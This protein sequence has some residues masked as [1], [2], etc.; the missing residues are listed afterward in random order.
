MND[1][2]IKEEILQEKAEFESKQDGMDKRAG[3]AE[4]FLGCIIALV[5]ICACALYMKLYN[6]TEHDSAVQIAVNEQVQQYFQLSQTE[7]NMSTLR[8]NLNPD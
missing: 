8:S 5:I 7:E 6:K 1:H 3:L 2:E 4:I